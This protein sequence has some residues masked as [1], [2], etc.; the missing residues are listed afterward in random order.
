M[1]STILTIVIELLLGGVCILIFTGDPLLALIVLGLVVINIAGLA[2]IMVTI[3]KWLIG[4]IEVICLVVF[5][6]YSV[7]FGLHIS[8]DYARVQEDDR[9]LL[10][11]NRVAKEMQRIGLRSFWRAFNANIKVT[12]SWN[13]ED[14]KGPCEQLTP[15]EQ[16]LE[17]TRMAM[18]HVGGAI[19]SAAFS[20]AGTSIFL[21]MCTL[22][23]FNKIGAVVM[24]ITLLSVVVT[25]VS[26]P[27]A[28]IVCGPNFHPCY[29]RCWKRGQ[30]KAVVRS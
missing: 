22:T 20:S 4:P 10:V 13:H 6:G 14:L 11:N 21:M 29:K 17:R 25:L 27:A 30:K 26:L 19:I 5:V 9:D 1:N 24:T 16:R 3:F 28:L 18:L 8:G 23:I 15:R 2:F 12:N 7:T